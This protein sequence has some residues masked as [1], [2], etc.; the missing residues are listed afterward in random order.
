MNAVVNSTASYWQYSLYQGPK[1]PQHRVKVHYCKNKEASEEAAKLFLHE[2]VIGFDIE[3]MAQAKATD[4]IKRNVSL[5]Q[6]A[7]E[8]RVALLHLARYP[9]A[10]QLDDFVTPSLKQLMES[11]DVTKVGVAIKG[12]STRLQKFL[13][14]TCR[15]LFELSYLYKLV[16]YCEGHLQKLDRKSV[17]LADQVN[18]HLLLPLLKGDVQTSNWACELTYPQTQCEC[19]H[20]RH[21]RIPQADRITRCGF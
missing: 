18:E 9:G 11:P 20:L 14:I 13:G 17:R 2:K 5:I 10:T 4:G 6:L 15:G 3:W 16:K 7:S 19:L 21:Y 1:G 8:E 12:D